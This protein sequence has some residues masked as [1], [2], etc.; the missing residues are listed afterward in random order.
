MAW[1]VLLLSV[2]GLLLGWCLDRVPGMVHAAAALSLSWG[3][4]MA[5]RRPAAGDGRDDG[6]PGLRLGLLLCGLVAGVVL[7]YGAVTALL[8]RTL[9]FEFKA[10]WRYEVIPHGLLDLAALGAA[11]LLA[12]RSQRDDRLVTVLMWLLAFAG[13]WLAMLS[14]PMTHDRSGAVGTAPAG[15]MPWPSVLML[16]L[17]GTLTGFTCLEGLRIQRRRVRAWPNHLINLTSPPR[18]WRG[19]RY[20]AGIIGVLVLVL[21]CVLIGFPRTTWGAVPAGLSLLILASRRWNENLADAG[22]ALITIGV[23]AFFIQLAPPSGRAPTYAEHFCRAM[24]GLTVMAFIWH[25]LAGVWVQQL[26]NRK[27]WTTTGR[28][29]RTAQRVGYLVAATA[30][31]IGFQLALWP[32]SEYVTE[33]DDSLARW[34]WGLG[35]YTLLV[36][37]LTFASV[38]TGKATLG[39][40]VLFTLLAMATFVGVRAPAGPELQW[41][42]YHWPAVLPVIGLVSVVLSA[43]SRK[44]RH[45]AA[46]TEPLLIGGVLLIPMSAL[47]GVAFGDPSGLNIAPGA[48]AA[49]FYL[50]SAVYLLAAFVPGPRTFLMLS[51]IL[52]LVGVWHQL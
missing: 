16:I 38:R 9:F 43:L 19:F 27:A 15:A 26:D 29:I 6:S 42:R 33:T 50:L 49:T 17:A 28:M 14:P 5:V 12:W 48:I 20:S 31:L 22:L 30:V 51:A 3:V 7:L 21:A 35:G 10:A 25:W 34:I 39:Y 23:V 8:M 11:V 37:M 24:V 45:G 32:R 47:A 2:G 1:P 52:A 44:T 40:L 46:F 41:W 36:L 13:L 18:S 4:L